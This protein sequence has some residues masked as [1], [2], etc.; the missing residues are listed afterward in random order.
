MSLGLGLNMAKT[1]VS[2]V[3]FDADAQAFID[4][5]SITDATQKDAINTLVIAL[6]DG[7]VWVKS[8]A[9]YPM[10]GGTAAKHK[11][12]LKDPRD[13]NAAFRLTFFGGW[14]HGANGALPNGT[15]AY[16]D[17]FL[18]PSVDIAD[19][20]DGHLSYYSRTDN[21]GSYMDIGCS[22]LSSS[23][24]LSCKFT[25]NI[26]VV[27]I[28]MADSNTFAYSGTTNAFFI[29]S[30]NNVNDVRR[31]FK[32]GV[33]LNNS[34]VA[35]N[36]NPDNSIAVGARNSGAARSFFSA[37]ECAFASAGLGFTDAEMLSFY[38]AVQAFNTSLSRQV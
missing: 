32:N 21:I 36:V 7:G 2:G 15:T 23:F 24:D 38:N 10:V 13:L 19:A 4:A 27:A 29:A 17:T 12:N 3:S 20:N 37:R 5:A 1:K 33:L 14:T 28:N 31:M 8:L 26:G 18:V 35:Q 6:K 30:Q 16:A 25:G 9:L 11:F 22:G 34:S